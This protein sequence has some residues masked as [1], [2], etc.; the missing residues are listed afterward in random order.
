MAFTNSLFSFL[1]CQ[2][3]EFVAILRLNWKLYLKWETIA[4]QFHCA[5]TFLVNFA[6]RISCFFNFVLTI[7]KGWLKKQHHI[8]LFSNFEK[9]F[10]ALCV[11]FWISVSSVV[12]PLSLN[13]SG[14]YSRF[15]LSRTWIS[16]EWLIFKQSKLNMIWLSK[17]RSDWSAIYIFQY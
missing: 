9:L 5:S 12:M 1:M 2:T 17:N 3:G 4:K 16:P 6:V 11:F 10:G 8:R 7:F 14:H 13:F 15:F